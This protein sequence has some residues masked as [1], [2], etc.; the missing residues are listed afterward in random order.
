[1]REEVREDSRGWGGGARGE[2]GSSCFFY[3]GGIRFYSSML[4][5]ELPLDKGI[6]VVWLPRT[7]ETLFRRKNRSLEGVPLDDKRWRLRSRLV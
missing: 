4:D 3:C 5:R 7:V 6:K 2:G 1:M